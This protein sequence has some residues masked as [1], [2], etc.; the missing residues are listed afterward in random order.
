MIF[1]AIFTGVAI[2]FFLA[3]I[4]TMGKVSDLHAENERLKRALR[5][6]EV[7]VA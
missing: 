6:G 2:G 4:L 1:V 5:K 3:A 7:D